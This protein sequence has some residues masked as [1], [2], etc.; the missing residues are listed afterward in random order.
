MNAIWMKMSDLDKALFVIL[1]VSLIVKVGKEIVIHVC[2]FLSKRMLSD[3]RC[4]FLEKKDDKYYCINLFHKRKFF[5][6]RN[7]CMQSK[8]LGFH[9]KG[10]ILDPVSSSLILSIILSLCDWVFLVSSTI[11]VIRALLGEK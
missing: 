1:V 8:C 2:V 11:L 5:K 6:K 10:K 4:V 7:K 9:P 3:C